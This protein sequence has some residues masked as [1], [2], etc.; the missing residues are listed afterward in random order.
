MRF[1]PIA[2][3]VAA[4]VAA[5]ALAATKNGITPLA[6]KAGATVPQGEAPTFRAR[7]R[8]PGKVWFHVCKS[9]RRNK[10][11]VICNKA[12][13][14]QGKKSGGRVYRYKVKFFDYP[15]FWL[16]RPGTYYWQAHRIYC[17]GGD[18]RQEGPIVRFR[19]G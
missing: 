15:D 14:G 10:D 2:A 3:V 13:I 18:C 1:L 11:G 17:K 6:P 4:L 19:V 5:P 7:V 9:K 12:S 16:N 8:G